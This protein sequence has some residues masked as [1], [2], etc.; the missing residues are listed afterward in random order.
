MTSVTPRSSA[1][2][3]AGCTAIATAAAVLLYLPRPLPQ[4]G[5]CC[6]S[7]LDKRL[8]QTYGCVMRLQ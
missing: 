6:G 5:L 7:V 2:T 1:H 3:A 8:L 4:A